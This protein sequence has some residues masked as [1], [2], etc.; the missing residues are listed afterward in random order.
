[1]IFWKRSSKCTGTATCVEVA[2]IDD[3][4]AVRSTDVYGRA[5]LMG[6]SREEWNAFTAGVKLG[7]FDYEK[8]VNT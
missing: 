5:R 6:F 2:V 4:V 8:L 7:E 3:R 1:M